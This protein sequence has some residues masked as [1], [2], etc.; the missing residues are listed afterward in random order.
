MLGVISDSGSSWLCT[1]AGGFISAVVVFGVFAISVELKAY[2]GA[3]TSARSSVS[4]VFLFA[5]TV[6]G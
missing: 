4:W 6:S 2:A 5:I 3:M 1:I